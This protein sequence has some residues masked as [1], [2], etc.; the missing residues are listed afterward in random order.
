MGRVVGGDIIDI[1][2]NTA[3]IDQ[4]YVWSYM[5]HKKVKYFLILLRKKII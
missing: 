5:E 4:G 2:I 3:I 1:G